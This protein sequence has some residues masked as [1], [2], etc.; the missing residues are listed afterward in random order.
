MIGVNEMVE[1]E[2]QKTVA[3]DVGGV[4]DETQMIKLLS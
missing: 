3:S 4:K 2:N 1:T